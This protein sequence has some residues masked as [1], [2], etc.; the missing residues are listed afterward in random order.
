MENGNGSINYW[1]KGNKP[2][3]DLRE[4]GKSNFFELKELVKAAAAAA[5]APPNPWKM[6]AIQFDLY[7][8]K[9]K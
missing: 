3:S 5:A 7:M 9:T 2:A 4:E 1:R 8:A 6:V